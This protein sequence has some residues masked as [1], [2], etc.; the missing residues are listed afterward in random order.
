MGAVV[1]MERMKRESHL[2]VVRGS[3]QSGDSHMIEG[4]T[5]LTNMDDIMSV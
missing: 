4:K 5:L 2:S 1:K 3:T